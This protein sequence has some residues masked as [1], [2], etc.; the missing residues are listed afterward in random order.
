MERTTPS[1]TPNVSGC[2]LVFEGGGR[3]GAYTAGF[4]RVLLEHEIRFPLVCGVAA[5][6]SHAVNYV[7]RDLRRTRST[8]V[9][10][11]SA[12]LPLGALPSLLHGSGPFAASPFIASPLAVSPFAADSP[13]EGFMEDD[14][15]PFDWDAFTNN[16]AD[17]R[18]QAFERDTGRTLTFGKKD[19]PNAQ[20][21]LDLIRVGSTRP[22]AMRSP[23]V[24][25]A[26]LLDG[27]LGKGAGISLHL[28]EEEGFGR[29]FLVTTRPKGYREQP[30]TARE[31]K[32]YELVSRDYPYLR[33]ALLTRW[34]RYNEELDRAERLAE[35]GRCLIA[36]PD[37]M[38]VESETLDPAL[39]RDA[40]DQGRHQ[41]LRDLPRWRRFLFGSEDG[42]PQPDPELM[43][44]RIR[45]A[46]GD[47][48]YITIRP[49]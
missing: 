48:G 49:S 44:Q 7:S 1:P 45:D 10:V 34:E 24:G 12:G 15:L 5:G 37:V 25:D 36:Y 30:P 43:R 38:P 2:A 39:L 33:N 47:D 35:E 28:A 13:F 22:G 20:A 32:A 17:V 46:D 27:G 9:D 4:V 26:A 14:G 29:F 11:R 18:I 6:A 21:L 40:Y 8:F 41:A 3:R 16:P 23:A 42:G 19:M 31:R